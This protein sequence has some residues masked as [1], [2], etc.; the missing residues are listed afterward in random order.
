MNNYP[1]IVVIAPLLGA[2]FA[3]VAA[4]VEDRATYP[5]ALASLGIAAAAAV[6]DL[7]TVMISGPIQYNMA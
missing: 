4:W 2:L 7:I 3:G 5:I 6:N 1:A